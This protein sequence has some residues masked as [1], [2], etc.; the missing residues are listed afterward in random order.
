M[1]NLPLEYP[2]IYGQTVFP[3][4]SAYGRIWPPKTL[5]ML[6][7]LLK[8]SHIPFWIDSKLC[9]GENPWLGTQLLETLTNARRAAEF[10]LHLPR[11]KNLINV[12]DDENEYMPRNSTRLYERKSSFVPNMNTQLTELKKVTSSILDFNSNMK[13][14]RKQFDANINICNKVI[15]NRLHN[16]VN[17]KE[18]EIPL[19]TDDFVMVYNLMSDFFEKKAMYVAGFEIPVS[20][21]SVSFCLTNSP[22]NKSAHVIGI[23]KL[24]DVLWNPSR[25]RLEPRLNEYKKEY[26]TKTTSSFKN[27]FHKKWFCLKNRLSH[28]VSTYYLSLTRHSVLQIY[29]SSLFSYALTYNS[30]NILISAAFVKATSWTTPE[31]Q[32]NGNASN[33]QISRLVTRPTIASFINNQETLNILQLDDCIPPWSNNDDQNTEQQEQ[34]GAPSISEMQTWPLPGERPHRRRRNNNKHVINE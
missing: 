34:F 30:N 20:F 22:Y 18:Q 13:F 33:N 4:S 23:C 25:T 14:K 24:S 31:H 8:Y 15:F 17:S 27:K 26:V 28:R 5:T 9:F 12:Y 16:K 3:I 7:P 1:E 6:E 19:C 21:R 10:F 29:P 32:K 2:T 11:V